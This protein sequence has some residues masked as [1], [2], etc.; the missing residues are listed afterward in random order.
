MAGLTMEQHTFLQALMALAVMREDEARTMHAEIMSGAGAGAGGAGGFESFWGQIKSALGF[1]DLDVCR[2]KYPE[3]D[4]LYIGIVNKSGGESA[5]LATKLTPEQI[6]LFRVVLDEILRDDTNA[7]HGV[8]MI[9]AINATQLWGATQGEGGAAA[10]GLGALSQAQTQSVQNMSKMDKEATLK[11]LCRDK[12]LFRGEDEAGHLKLGVRAFLELKE[13][14]LDEA[15]PA[16]K[17]R[18]D[19][20]L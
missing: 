11:M 2:V 13:F 5:K 7:E 10:G 8:D 4:Q 16:A 6:A 9:S 12:W 20:M 19:K 3:D 1:L 15:P 18:W 17:K 14:L